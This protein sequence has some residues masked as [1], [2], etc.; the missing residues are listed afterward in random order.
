[1]IF[2]FVIP[3]LILAAI[4]GLFGIRTRIGFWGVFLLSIIFTPILTLLFLFLLKDKPK[5]NP[6]EAKFD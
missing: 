4:A 2:E 3:Y 6:F 1:M 5:K